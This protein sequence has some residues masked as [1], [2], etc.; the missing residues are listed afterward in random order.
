MIILEQTII[1]EELLD[2]EFVCNLSACKGACC[3][4]GDIGA[5][6]TSAE[7]TIITDNINA[8]IPYM[9]EAG[10]GLLEERGFYEYD[11]DGELVTTCIDGN[12]CV[13]VLTQP[14]G[15]HK[16]AIE[17][18]HLAGKLEF[19]KPLS[20]H[21]YPIRVSKV[22]GYD[23][24]NYNRWSVCSPAC[25]LGEALGMPIYKFLKEPL[26]RAYGP[27]WYQDLEQIAEAY[28]DES[29]TAL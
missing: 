14:D 25:S 12:E 21:L 1:S 10:I 17:T 23:A 9:S 19:H 27:V 6:I 8:I 22:G 26:I 13:F 24:L 28:T 29:K 18:A 4:E 20:C 5:P 7:A 3:V 11:T 15:I 2:N 16:C